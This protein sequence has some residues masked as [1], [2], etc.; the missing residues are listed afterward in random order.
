M[1]TPDEGSPESCLDCEVK[2]LVQERVEGQEKADTAELPANLEEARTWYYVVDCATCAAVIPFKYAP[3]DEPILRFPT[4]RVRCFQCHTHHTY[5]ADLVSRRKAVA[6]S[7]ISRRGQ[8]PDARD[9]ADEASPHQQDDRN[10]GASGGREIVECKI[11][12]DSSSLRR[13]HIGIEPVSG[14]RVAVFFLS[15]CFFAAGWVFQLLL[16]IFYPATLNVHSEPR[17]YGPAL[18]LDSAFFGTVLFGLTFFIVGT[19]SL[20]VDRYGCMRDVLRKDVSVLPER[21]AFIQSLPLVTISLDRMAKA[22]SFA[23]QASR[24]LSTF[25]SRAATI[26]TQIGQSA[27]LRLKQYW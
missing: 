1:V 7:E 21:N 5:S 10:L 9:G 12:P 23:Q 17:L 4:M 19:G 13:A 6:P 2:E 8:M 11:D 3:E 24:V 15:S 16:N 27:K 22:I 20:L 25:S 14:K 18:L 26:R